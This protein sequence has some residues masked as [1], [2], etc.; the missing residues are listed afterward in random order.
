MNPRLLLRLVLD[1]MAAGL[2]FAALAYYWL[3]N[4]AHEVMGAGMFALLLAHGIFHRRWFAKVAVKRRERAGRLDLV[5]TLLLLLAMLLLLASSLLI[6][7]T[8]LG[9]MALDDI[10]VARQAHLLAA[11]WVVLLVGIHLGLRWTIVMAALRKALGLV[12]KSPTRAI[13]LRLLTVSVALYGLRAW[14]AM[15]VGPKL[16]WLPVLEMWDFSESTAGFFANYGAI[17]ALYASLTHYAVQWLQR[18]GR[19]G[20]TVRRTTPAAI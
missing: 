15:A 10:V 4:T 2:L 11:Q 20:N 8:V 13:G 9:F 18:M 6:S 17:V 1:T 5:L 19:G 16:L 7:R 14:F 3:D 12:G